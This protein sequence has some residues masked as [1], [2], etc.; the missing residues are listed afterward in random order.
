MEATAVRLRIVWTMPSGVRF[1]S[2]PLNQLPMDTGVASAH[3]VS[4][5]QQLK[6]YTGFGEV[7]IRSRERFLDVLG[8]SS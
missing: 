6:V 8:V 1:I 7:G 5:S 2:I 3:P 4:P